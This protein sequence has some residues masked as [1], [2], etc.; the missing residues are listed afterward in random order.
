M[1]RHLI[2]FNEKDERA[3][4][5][6]DCLNSIGNMKGKLV[7]AL[8]MFCLETYGPLSKENIREI[9]F[10]IE[11]RIGTGSSQASV[12]RTPLQVVKRR[13]T[14]KKSGDCSEKGKKLSHDE[15]SRTRTTLKSTS[16]QP[17]SVQESFTTKLELKSI[18]K[19]SIESCRD[20]IRAID[21]G[22]D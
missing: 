13:T 21:E 8:L 15:A 14:V 2:T 1:G 7:M 12:P 17:G 22:W 11:N 18:S 3:A 9:I 10:C 20:I 6:D 5:C 19:E 4:L 16:E